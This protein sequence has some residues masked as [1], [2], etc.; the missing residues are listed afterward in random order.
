MLLNSILF[1]LNTNNLPPDLFD[2]F[3]KPKIYTAYGGYMRKLSGDEQFRQYVKGFDARISMTPDLNY[4]WFDGFFIPHAIDSDRFQYSWRDGRVLAHSPSTK[5]RKGTD[6]LVAAVN[7]LGIEFD[8]ISGVS[9]EECVS[10]KSSA[11][12]FF[13]QAGRE[14]QERLGINTVIGWYGN[15]ALEAA[16]F[17]IPTIA[18]LSE[19]AYDGAAR[20]GRDIRDSCAI[21]N[22]PLGSAGIRRTLEAYFLQGADG[23]AELSRRTRRWIEEFHS[24]QACADELGKVYRGLL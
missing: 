12:L 14:I 2:G 22:T 9:H 6:D 19:H 7:G 3:D 15:S 10:R 21:L 16:V 23:R 24:Y 18:H 11:N 13:D 20:A 17:G 1:F 4:D 8:L 5:E